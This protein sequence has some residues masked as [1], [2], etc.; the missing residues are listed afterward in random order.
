MKMCFF[1]DFGTTYSAIMFAVAIGTTVSC[2]LGKQYEQMIS[3]D[4]FDVYQNPISVG[5]PKVA[6]PNQGKYI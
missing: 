4:Y 2:S 6:R 1:L 3:P 5:S